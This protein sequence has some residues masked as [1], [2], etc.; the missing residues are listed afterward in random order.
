MVTLARALRMVEQRTEQMAR[1]QER[2]MDVSGRIADNTFG[3][4]L[5]RLDVGDL[6]ACLHRLVKAEHRRGNLKATRLPWGA[7]AIDGT[8]TWRRCIGPICCVFW[9]LSQTKS[10][11]RKARRYLRRSTHWHRCAPRKPVRR[12]R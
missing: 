11:T 5:P 3:K 10:P 8:R 2:W 6:M 7:V 12:M 9:G 4:V 1:K